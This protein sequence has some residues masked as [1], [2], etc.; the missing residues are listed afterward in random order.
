MA[1]DGMDPCE[2]IWSAE[3]GMRRLLSFVSFMEQNYLYFL[4]QSV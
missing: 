2:C 3:M 4:V 1:D